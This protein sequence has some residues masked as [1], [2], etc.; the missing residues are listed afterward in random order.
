MK[1]SLVTLSLYPLSA[2]FAPLRSHIICLAAVCRNTVPILIFT[3]P[4]SEVVFLC[5]GLP[6]VPAAA[7]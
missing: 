3:R 2:P 4:A 6:S 1:V 7:G 5:V